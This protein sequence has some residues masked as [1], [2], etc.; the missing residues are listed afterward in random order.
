MFLQLI[1]DTP[2]KRNKSEIVYVEDISKS[3]VAETYL[4]KTEITM[5]E[6][7]DNSEE[8]SGFE[9]LNPVRLGK[10]HAY[11][12]YFSEISK[13]YE[14]ASLNGSCYSL[15]ELQVEE[16]LRRPQE[17]WSRLPARAQ[18]K[19]HLEA[20]KPL[21]EKILNSMVSKARD[22]DEA[23]DELTRN[24]EKCRS[25]KEKWGKDNVIGYKVEKVGSRELVNFVRISNEVDEHSQHESSEIGSG[26]SSPPATDIL[27]HLTQV[28]L[29]ES[30]A[31]N[32]RIFESRRSLEGDLIKIMKDYR[33]VWD[34][35]CRALKEHPK[36]QQAWKEIAMKLKQDGEPAFHRLSSIGS[37][38]SLNCFCETSRC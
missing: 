1:F 9:V 36:K 31:Q 18:P 33:C 16:N 15:S 35:S 17:F 4:E 2:K 32:E 26:N 10:F 5:T 20:L 7:D 14:D 3:S 19:E 37:L 23:K 25:F 13:V 6:S 30:E 38:N 34:V 22:D 11:L 8:E 27:G 29:R 12:S 24:I 28:T 21:D